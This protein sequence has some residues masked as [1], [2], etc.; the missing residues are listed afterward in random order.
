M[1][2]AVETVVWLLVS[3]HRSAAI[4]KLSIATNL[5]DLF[6]RA[7]HSQ[8]IPSSPQSP[9]TSHHNTQQLSFD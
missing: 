9:V 7:Q 5:A 3:R 2:F 6:K 8:L 4:S 1:S